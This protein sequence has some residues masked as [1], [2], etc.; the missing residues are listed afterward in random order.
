[1]CSSRVSSRSCSGRRCDLRQG[2]RGTP[3][4]TNRLATGQTFTIV[5]VPLLLAERVQ[6]KAP[7]R[8][9][10]LDYLCLR[11]NATCPRGCDQTS[12]RRAVYEPCAQ[13][14]SNLAPQR[15]LR[16]NGPLGIVP[17]PP[18]RDC[19]IFAAASGES[20]LRLRSR[21]CPPRGWTGCFPR[22]AVLDCSASTG[23]AAHDHAGLITESPLSSRQFSG[24][25]STT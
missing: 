15:P 22:G 6:A 20:Q 2:S 16:L 7:I 11:A 1:V 24:P 3:I 19:G 13:R 12:T 23:E 10:D 4:W 25:G 8:S 21:D 18:R 5:A 17:R 9:R 14:R